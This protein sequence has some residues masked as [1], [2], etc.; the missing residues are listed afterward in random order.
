MNHYTQVAG[1][2]LWANTH[3]HTVL[4]SVENRI[5]KFVKHYRIAYQALLQLDPTSDWWETYLELKDSD[6]HGPGKESGEE[7]AGNGTYFRSWIWLPNPQVL[8]VAD[9]G[10][11]EEGASEEDVNEL[12]RVEWT[13]SFARLERWTEEVDLLQEEMRRVIVFLEWKSQGWLAKVGARGGNLAL[14]IK[15]GLNAYAKKQAAIYHDLAVLFAKFWH[16]TLVSY[17]LKHSPVM[18]YMERHRFS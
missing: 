18:E 14:D 8:G 5:T 11:G 15:S 6:N 9:G 1:Q 2:G 17:S 13:T 4:N 7:G 16:P 12:L 10:G 3:S